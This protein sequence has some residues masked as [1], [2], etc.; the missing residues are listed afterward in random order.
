MKR[1]SK[2][3]HTAPTAWAQTLAPLRQTLAGLQPRER[4]AVTL[5]DGRMPLEVSGGVSLERVAEIAATGVD[6]I[7]V[8][9]LTKHVRAVDLSMRV[10]GEA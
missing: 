7:S 10:L 9:A 6:F 2:T 4:R 5:A 1:A 3:P 8:G